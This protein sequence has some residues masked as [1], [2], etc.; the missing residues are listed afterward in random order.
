MVSVQ[1]RRAAVAFATT[2]GV[3]QR[4]ACTLLKVTRSAL[5]YRSRKTVKDAAPL[6][7]MSELSA[8]YPRYGYRRIAIFLARDGHDMSVR[9]LVKDQAS[10][11]RR[12]A[13]S[14]HS[15][16]SHGSIPLDQSPTP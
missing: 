3:S 15:R 6:A 11:P 9:L 1:A 7:R 10:P 8:Q 5:G 16:R 2:R 13:S 4:R 14:A 12:P